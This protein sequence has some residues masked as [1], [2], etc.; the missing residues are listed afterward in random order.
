MRP[1]SLLHPLGERRHSRRHRPR[2]AART[3]EPSASPH[4]P[5][6][7]PAVQRVR[8]AGG[9]MDQASYACACG[10]LFHASVSTT[11]S[12]PHCGADQTW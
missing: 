7:D 12:C 1:S 10:Y 2:R 9:P 3:G 5:P 4:D 11:V 8:E 6:R